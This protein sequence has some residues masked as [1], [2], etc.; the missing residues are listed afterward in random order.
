MSIRVVF[1]DTVLLAV[2]EGFLTFT[3]TEDEEL[4]KLS[5]RETTKFVENLCIG[6]K[7]APFKVPIA[8][9]GYM[10]Q[11]KLV[12]GVKEIKL[13][14]KDLDRLKKALIVAIPNLLLHDLI[15]Q[16]YVAAADSLVSY[17]AD[18]LTVEA[19]QQCFKQIK[20]GVPEDKVLDYYVQA[21]V[22]T[23][24]DIK[25]LQNFIFVNVKLLKSVW[26]L[27][28]ITKKQNAAPV[29]G[30]SSSSD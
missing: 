24:C 22:Q 20:L 28:T 6:L 16:K 23:Q 5:C 17:V 15:S 3:S 13:S 19:G 14:A 18:T 9:A 4:A 10:Y 12:F 25:T 30:T 2:R 27:R 1:A 11:D 7:K 8:D 21:N 29:A 26:Q